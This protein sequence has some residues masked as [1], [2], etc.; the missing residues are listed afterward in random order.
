MGFLHDRQT[1]IELAIEEKREILVM[2][3]K[4]NIEF[5]DRG[6]V[7]KRGIIILLV[8]F[9]L[10]ACFCTNTSH[11]FT[12]EVKVAEGLIEVVSWDSIQVKGKTFYISEAL[13]KDNVGRDVSKI[14]YLRHHS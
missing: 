8:L 11:G 6:F 13:I 5:R 2:T 3:E 9:V 14:F 12:K 7:M 1:G 10:I 4:D